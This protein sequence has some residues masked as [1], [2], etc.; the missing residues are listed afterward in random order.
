MT[1]T[2]E[3]NLIERFKQ[4][5]R[6]AF[7]ELVRKFQDRIYNLCRYMLRDPQNAQDA[8][9]DVFLKA[10]RALKDF[11]PDA[12]FYTWIY[13]IAVTT[14]LDYR[15]K[16]HREALRSAPLTEDLPSN[17]P[18][19]HQ[20]YESREI[21]ESIQIALQKLPDKLRAAIVLREIEGCSYEE[22]AQVLHASVGTVKSRIWRARNQLR[23]LLKKTG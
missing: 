15:R 1:S 18:S 19:P 14:C 6:S 21:A 11:R 8:A 22:I 16:S 12:S 13:R 17:A 3:S 2:D 5:D 4:G 10:Y 9:Q 23:R 7:E 20:L